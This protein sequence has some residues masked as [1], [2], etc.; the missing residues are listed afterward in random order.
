M[1]CST[2]VTQHLLRGIA[3]AALLVLA[4]AL[5]STHVVW[6]LLAAGGA[7]VLLRGCPMCWLAGLFETVANRRATRTARLRG[8]E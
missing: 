1:F 6:A 4:V 8:P 7:L 2:S 5:F 3:G